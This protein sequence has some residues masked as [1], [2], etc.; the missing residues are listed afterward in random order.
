VSVFRLRPWIPVLVWAAVIFSLSTASFSDDHTSTILIP[1]FHWLLPRATEAQLL[2]LHYL[3]RE[4]AHL[5]EYFV[6]GWLLLTAIRGRERGWKLRW[7]LLAFLLAAGY[8]AA[9]EWH[10][11]FV[12]GRNSSA[13]DSLLDT[14]GAAA[15]LPTAWIA[16]RRQQQSGCDAAGSHAA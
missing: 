13:W 2:L 7:A 3:T 16:F 5:T 15:A 10:Q 1:A 14:T 12:A 6:M 8:S 11:S 4:G 9:D